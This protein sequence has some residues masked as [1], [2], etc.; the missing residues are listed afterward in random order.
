MPLSTGELK[1]RRAAQR[2]RS[3]QHR[4]AFLAGLIVLVA[5]ATIALAN[6]HSHGLTSRVAGQTS[7]VGGQHHG[8]A[9]AKA[10]TTHALQAED[11]SAARETNSVLGYT[12]YVRL[13]AHRHRDVALTFDDGPSSYTPQILRVLTRMHAKATFFEIGYAVRSYP[14][15]T[16]EEARDG[17]EIGDHTETHAYLQEISPAEQVHEIEDQMEALRHAG[18][19]NPVLFRPPYGSFNATTLSIL[20]SQKLLMVLWSVDTSDYARPGVDKIVDTA[21]SGATPGAIILMHDG[22]GDRSE[23]VKALPQIIRGLRR[24]GYHLMTVSQLVAADPPPHHQ[25]PPQPLSG[26]G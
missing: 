15:L 9:P 22:G 23:T 4:L 17:F 14:K 8:D 25:P 26:L 5:V 24:R 19:P 2:R 21:L 10:R 20:H 6:G 7:A 16:A 12:S 3:R 13:L 1:A 11:A 18:A